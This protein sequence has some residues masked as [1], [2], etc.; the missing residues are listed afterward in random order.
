MEEDLEEIKVILWEGLVRQLRWCGIWGDWPSA[1]AKGDFWRGRVLNSGYI[2]GLVCL[3]N[4]NWVWQKFEPLTS[5]T[6]MDVLGIQ[7]Q[8]NHSPFFFSC[9]LPLS[10]HSAPGP[11]APIPTISVYCTP[12]CG[13][14]F[15]A[16][17]S[18]PSNTSESPLLPSHAWPAPP[19][20]DQGPFAFCLVFHFN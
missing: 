13:H 20:L 18:R 17:P 9:T 10:P 1:T 8:L 3:R 11:T 4:L 6:W 19:L 16:F 12:I 5:W 7:A 14:S 2:E 15:W